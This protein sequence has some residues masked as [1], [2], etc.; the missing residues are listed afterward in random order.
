[1]PEAAPENPTRAAAICFPATAHL[2]GPPMAPKRHKIVMTMKHPIITS[3]P[4][5][6]LKE[7]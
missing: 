2:N 5:M 6:K 7:S 1:M 4:E 3:S